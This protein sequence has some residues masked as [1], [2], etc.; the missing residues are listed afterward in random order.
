VVKGWLAVLTVT[1]VVLV[2]LPVG[3]V[4]AEPG[5]PRLLDWYAVV[6]DDTIGIGTVS[7][8]AEWTRVTR[9]TEMSDEVHVTVRSFHWPFIATASIGHEVVL[10]VDLHQPLGERR[11]VDDFHVVPPRK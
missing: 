10:T 8:D 1:V 3:F 6:D 4:A 9:V 2:L 11:V 5:V 7:G